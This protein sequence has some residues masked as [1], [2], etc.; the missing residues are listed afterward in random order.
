MHLVPALPAVII[1]VSGMPWL[2]MEGN[3][4]SLPL[5]KYSS[6]FEEHPYL[7]TFFG[8]EVGQHYSEMSEGK[9][10]KETKSVCVCVIMA[11]QTS[12]HCLIFSWIG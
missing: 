8:Q 4:S 7:R 11:V 6:W 2:T 12:N 3:T 5:D 9:R 1:S 10:N